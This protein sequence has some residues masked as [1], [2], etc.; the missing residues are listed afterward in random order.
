VKAKV[1]HAMPE[2]ITITGEVSGLYWNPEKAVSAISETADETILF[3]KI[4]V[5]PVKMPA[6]PKTGIR[7]SG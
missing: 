6:E 5:L 7:K 1:M 4:L 3:I 2:A